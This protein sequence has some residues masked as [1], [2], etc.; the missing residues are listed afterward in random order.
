MIR[1]LF[2]LIICLPH[3]AFAQNQS[4]YK[5]PNLSD[6]K[7]LPVLH[8]G[9]IKPLDSFARIYLK[10]F[11]HAPRLKDYSASEWLAQAIFTPERAIQHDLFQSRDERGRAVYFSYGAL[12]E[13]IQANSDKIEVLAEQ[14]VADLSS[15]QR[16]LMALYEN[17]I[18]HTQIL[19]S[20][21][22]FLTP[23]KDQDALIERLKKIIAKKGHDLDLYTPEEKEIAAQSYT[24]QLLNDNAKHNVLLRVIP[25]K[26]DWISPWEAK[27]NNVSTNILRAWKDM[28]Q[29]Y[30]SG[31]QEK[32]D[33]AI[34]EI[35]SDLKT[36]SIKLKTE[37]L[38][39]VLSLQHIAALLYGLAIICFVIS[40]FYRVH[41]FEK[42][43]LI[44]L[45]T[46]VV[47]NFLHIALRVYILGRP[48]IG[49]LYESVLFVA[50]VCAA[51]YAFLARKQRN[52]NH[53][54]LGGIAGFILLLTAQA[55]AGNDTMGPLVAVLNTD[56]WLVTHV[57][58]ITLGYG[59]CL[60]ASF[61]AHYYLIQ[62]IRHKDTKEIFTTIKTLSIFSLLLVTVGT[63]LGGLWADQSWGRFW[64]WDPKE[65]GA[66][67]IVL[68]LI[69]VLHGHLTQHLN[70]M[71]FVIGMALLSIIVV[72]AW[73][74]V[75]LLNIG[76]H[77]YG[78]ISGVAWGIGLFCAF[79]VTL[80]AALWLYPKWKHHEA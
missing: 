4:E 68:W 62:K 27:R 26:Q 29:A 10:T 75:N 73:F 70:R 6:W 63:I 80:I 67:L 31:D 42:L 53:T 11:L 19:R 59:T 72:L 64:G 5:T 65:N 79:E 12:A 1:A 76:L 21:T 20:T 41:F 57:I 55:F 61:T 8:E 66:L 14:N 24:F 49:T 69:W 47:A 40:N 48:P 78:F 30:R 16:E 35:K 36:D 17:F 46:G 44:A 50:L 77:S 33:S 15:D 18:L 52:P 7:T 54:L 51:G 34:A 25:N 22:L 37:V 3:F 71:G 74:G 39:N 23:E 60:L 13:Y 43:A 9:R 58:C 45:T 32:W 38:F 56:F 2:L 28:A